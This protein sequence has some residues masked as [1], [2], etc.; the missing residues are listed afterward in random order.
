LNY[1]TPLLAWI[2]ALGTLAGAAHELRLQHERTDINAA[3]SAVPQ[4]TVKSDALGQKDYLAI[5]KKTAVFGSV[6][7]VVSASSLSVKSNALSDY[8]AWRLTLDQVLL[9]NPGVTWKVESLCSGKCSSGEAL[10]AVLQGS[11]MSTIV[12]PG[13]SSPAQT[14]PSAP[15]SKG[16]VSSSGPVSR[17]VVSRS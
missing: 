16:S 9:D 3:L 13:T 1:L 8:A 4:Y 5:Q 12:K 11:R 6:D 2:V 14:T 15:T 7:I 10:K 17:Y